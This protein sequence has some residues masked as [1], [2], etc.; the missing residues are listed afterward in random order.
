MLAKNI[1]QKANVM[2]LVPGNILITQAEELT[3]SKAMPKRKN[4]LFNTKE[5]PCHG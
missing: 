1:L 5:Q 3:A 4:L 2:T